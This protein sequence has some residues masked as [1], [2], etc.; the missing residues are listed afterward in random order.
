MKNSKCK[1]L[2]MFLTVSHL[3]P[4]P[5]HSKQVKASFTRKAIASLLGQEVWRQA[6]TEP[7]RLTKEATYP[8]VSQKGK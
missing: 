6:K 7:M 1:E 5:G 4:T 3:I 2:S 8:V